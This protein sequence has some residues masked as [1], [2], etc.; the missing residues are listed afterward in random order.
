MFVNITSIDLA[1]QQ[2][3]VLVIQCLFITLGA[4]SITVRFYISA[5]M[6]TKATQK[7][8]ESESDCLYLFNDYFRKTIT[9]EKVLWS[10]S[11]HVSNFSVMKLEY[12]D[13]LITANDGI[14]ADIAVQTDS[15]SYPNTTPAF[16]KINTASSNLWACVYLSAKAQKYKNM[17]LV[18]LLSSPKLSICCGLYL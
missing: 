8:S 2:E 7:E 5:K 10:H 6:A 1:S 9:H 18:S 3:M 4:R 17:V 15:F 16:R 11:R 12:N 14:L 13:P